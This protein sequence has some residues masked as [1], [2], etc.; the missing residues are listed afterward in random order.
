MSSESV[1]NS[2][3]ITS[4]TDPTRDTREHADYEAGEAARRAERIA[5]DALYEAMRRACEWQGRPFLSAR[6][7]SALTGVSEDTLRAL[8]RARHLPVAHFGNRLVVPVS[9]FLRW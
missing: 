9:P 8:M 6:E 4:A 2:T 5:G 7:L 3:S 1:K